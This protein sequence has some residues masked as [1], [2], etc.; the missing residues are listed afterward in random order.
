MTIICSWCRVEGRTGV[1]GEK[2]PLDDRRETHGICVTH[3]LAV[4]ARWHQRILSAEDAGSRLVSFDSEERKSADSA[5][6][7]RITSAQWWVSL[8]R[9]T[10]R[11]RS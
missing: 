4:Q 11:S 1:V 9:L 2:A 10:R 5:G 7:Q 3:R 6:V 8:K